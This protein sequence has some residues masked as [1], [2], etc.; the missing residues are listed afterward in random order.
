MPQLTLLLGILTIAGQQAAEQIFGGIVKGAWMRYLA[1][2]TTIGLA[3]AA[4]ILAE[5]LGLPEYGWG[6]TA[7]VGVLAGLGSGVWHGV[8]SARFPGANK[9]TISG[10]VGKALLWPGRPVQGGR[11]IPPSPPSR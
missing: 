2:A 10:A 9:A 3:F 6:Q 4:K 7:V 8:I 11:M 5:D 1:L